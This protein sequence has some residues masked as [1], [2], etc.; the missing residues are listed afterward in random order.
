M[1]AFSNHYLISPRIDFFLIGGAALLIYFIV[2]VFGFPINFDIVF[3]MVVLSFFVNSPH[4]MIS[5]EI[6]YSLSKK[7]L[8]KLNKFFFVGVFIPII[9]LSVLLYGFVFKSKNSFLLMLLAMFFLVGWHYIKQ[10]YG[11]FIVYSA[12][13]K[14]FYNKFEQSIIKFSL[15][16]LWFFS[17][18]KLFSSEN[19]N[20][21][22]LEYN[23]SQILSPFVVIM[24]WISL[25]GIVFFI[26]LILYNI[27][28][29]GKKPNIVALTSIIVVYI[30]LSP[31]LWNE[32]YFYMIPFFHSLQYFLF[33]GAY[34]QS[35]IEKSNT[36]LKGW[37]L[38]WGIAF[39]LGLLF[40]EIIPKVLDNIYPVADSITPNLF[41]ISFIFFINIHHYFI[42]SIIWKGGNI[43]VRE[44]LIF[45]SIG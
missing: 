14:V 32:F 17:F 36:G 23:F 1:I 25:S 7:N 4:F 3:W 15:Y 45:K 39:I 27:F 40:F 6:F 9:L 13:N 19:N 24:G 31:L 22:G 42:D 34:T 35:K 20:Y 5:Y 30:W 28:I 33:S 10:A 44:N 2:L 37:L 21:W 26:G 12:G 38:W 16:P 18:L 41:L 11:C 43:D 8:F 29:N